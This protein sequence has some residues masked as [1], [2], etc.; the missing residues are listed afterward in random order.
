MIKK[1]WTLFMKVNAKSLP[2]EIEE[3]WKE[4]FE[5]ML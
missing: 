5:E 3:E 2:S 4:T 1:E